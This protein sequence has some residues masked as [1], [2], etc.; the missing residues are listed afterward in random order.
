MTNYATKDDIKLHQVVMMGA[1]LKLSLEQQAQQIQYVQGADTQNIQQAQYVQ[2]PHRVDW[3]KFALRLYNRFARE[4]EISG[5]TIANHILQQPA[6]FL[7]LGEQRKVNINLFWV[8]YEVTR[9]AALCQE[10]E[11]LEELEETGENQYTTFTANSGQPTTIYDKYRYRGS[12]LQ[13]LCFYEYCCQ[14]TT[15]KLQYSRASDLRFDKE[16]PIYDSLC[17][18]VAKE[19]KDM[20]TPSIYGK[21]S[22]LENQQDSITGEYEN[23][24]PILNDH[25]QV[26][27]GL[28]IPWNQL[29]ALFEEY[30][31]GY[32]NPTDACSYVWDKIK[33][34][35]PPYIQRL[36]SNVSLLRKSKEDAEAD[37]LAREQELLDFEDIMLENDANNEND[38]NDDNDIIPY[39]PRIMSK[40]ELFHAY[41]IIMA[42]WKV[43]Q[44]NDLRVNS[45]VPLPISFL[46]I[47]DSLSYFEDSVLDLWKLQFKHLSKAISKEQD[48]ELLD[49]YRLRYQA[50]EAVYEPNIVPPRDYSI[51]I[52][53]A[54]ARLGSNPSVDDLFHYITTAFTPNEKQ[55]LIIR[56]VLKAILKIDTSQLTLVT[57][58]SQQFLL[59]IGGCGGTGK[60]QVI[61]AILFAMEL[62]GLGDR[63]CVTASTG[64]AAAHIKGQTIHSALGITAQGKGLSSTRL[65]TLQNILRSTIL[66][67]V[68]EISMVS[69]KLLGQ[70]NQNCTK[71]FELPTTGSAVFGGVPIVL[72]FGDFFQ[73]PPI[74]G[75]PLWTSKP[76]ES[77][78]DLERVGW[79]TWRKFNQVIILTE[80]L[81]QREDKIYQGILQ[82]AR[83]VTLTQGDI[84][85]LN[86]CT[87]AQRQARG[88][89]LPQ[90][91]ITTKNKLRHELNRMHVI[92]FARARNQKVYIFPARHKP[93]ACKSQRKNA[94][95]LFANPTDISFSRMLEIDDANPLK[96][97]GLLF[98][99]K[100]M[101]VMCLGNISTRSGVVN[102]MCGTAKHIVPDPA[103]K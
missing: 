21:I 9:I 72:F 74:G 40:L 97:A 69:T 83:D 8:R 22:E 59:Y 90:L 52:E 14:V 51:D 88:D 94:M 42:K 39:Q 13:E 15:I 73:F 34:L 41:H 37:R 84:D 4:R 25:C 5:V 10:S 20:I 46:K 67:I 24:G 82:R 58:S 89:P 68:D 95:R 43:H 80:C 78:P 57:E 45:L 26:L 70:V 76:I 62:L 60:T 49:T 7:P 2:E 85:L 53:D 99:T 79:D 48:L 6:F 56:N 18:R 28:F 61:N 50:E 11:L 31:M 54:R 71:I 44:P 103:G 27:L 66:F 75:D 17:Q 63:P 29:P 91:S 98:Y 3:S 16:Y 35:Q 38:D 77:F 1:I 100:D 64:A 93:I 19:Y 33:D 102:G 12:E 47:D 23:I 81:R 32:T 30:S 87:I 65:S 92:D 96:G 86:T 36:A 55:S 101:P